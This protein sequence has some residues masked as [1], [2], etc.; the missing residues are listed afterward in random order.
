MPD[1]ILLPEKLLPAHVTMEIPLAVMLDHVNLQ[2]LPVEESFKTHRTLNVLLLQMRSSHVVDHQGVSCEELTAVRTFVTG[3]VDVHHMPLHPVVRYE[4]L[5]TFRTLD[6]FG[7]VRATQMRL[8]MAIRSKFKVA[9]AAL[10]SYCVVLRR[11]MSAQIRH[12]SERLTAVHTDI[13]IVGVR[14]GDVSQQRTEIPIDFSAEGAREIIF[15]K[16]VWLHVTI[17]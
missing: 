13:L 7:A 8:E 3:A 15:D 14:L 12:V 5:L 4:L 9:F 6:Y 16:F 1:E 10:V 17:D 2:A 11:Y